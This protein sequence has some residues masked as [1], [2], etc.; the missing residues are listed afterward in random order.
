MPKAKETVK[1]DGVPGYPKGS[2]YGYIECPV[3][4]EGHTTVESNDFF[5]MGVFKESKV[6]EAYEKNCC[7]KEV[8]NGKAEE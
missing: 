3:H 8:I 4:K 6:K 2:V 5:V 1:N 7:V